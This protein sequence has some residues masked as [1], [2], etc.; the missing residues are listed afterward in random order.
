MLEETLTPQE[1]LDRELSHLSSLLPALTDM[2]GDQARAQELLS[3]AAAQARQEF[4]RQNQQGG[5][6]ATHIER[7]IQLIKA[8]NVALRESPAA[9]RVLVVQQQVLAQGFKG[10]SEEAKDQ[11]QELIALQDEQDR[12]KKSQEEV[13]QSVDKV[14]AAVDRL[15]RDIAI[16][17]LLLQP[18][19]NALADIQ[20]VFTDTFQDIFEGGVTS[21]EE[22]GDRIRDIFTR[23]AADILAKLI[24]DPERIGAQRQVRKEPKPRWRE[25]PQSWFVPAND[26]VPLGLAA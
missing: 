4:E 21:F 17:N 13:A 24:F 15:P 19:E 14:G 22:L 8:Q 1:K 16:E 12:L 18:F 7:Q 3:R 11:A 2:V 20:G 6:T 10:T 26:D 23:L 9:Y 5:E 25:L